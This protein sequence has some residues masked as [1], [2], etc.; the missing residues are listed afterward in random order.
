MR[1]FKKYVNE[2]NE[3]FYLKENNPIIK[4]KNLI[5]ILKKYVTAKD[6]KGK[7][8]VVFNNDIRLKTGELFPAS[9]KHI[10]NCNIHGRQQITYN[11]R[12]S[13]VKIPE[14]Y[15][16][17]CPKCNDFYLSDKYSPTETDRENCIQALQNI[18]FVSSNQ[19]TLKYFKKYMPQ[20]FKIINNFNFEPPL[21]LM[22]SEKIYFLKNKIFYIPECNI[23]NCKE[24][25]ILVKRP[26]FGFG[27]YCEK[28]KNSNY[29]SKKEN[30]IYDFVKNNYINKIEKNYRKFK[31]NELD[32]YLPDLNLGIE[33]NGLYWHSEKHVEKNHHYNKFM[34]FK[35]IGIKLITIWEDDWRFKQNIIKSILCNAMNINQEKIDA[36]KCTIQEIN[37]IEKTKFLNENHIQ[38]NCSSSINIALYHRDTIVSLITFGKNRM[39]LGQKN[40]MNE[41]ELLRFCSKL[42]CNVRGGASKLFNY[43]INNYKPEQIISYANLDIGGGNMYNILGFNNAENTKINY[44][45]SDFQHRYHRSGFM[46]HKLVK[47][48]ADKN[49]T[50]AEIMN[51]RG[52]YRIWGIGNGKWIW[53]RKEN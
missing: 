10:Y 39:I 35:N 19:Q 25:T 45:W 16:I 4:E 14:K 31:N 41:Y 51:E 44:W 11:I 17:Y 40:L 47:E 34:F 7:T 5:W 27:L 8:H 1:G 13:N 32:I 46:K 50:E 22:F 43:F 26:G 6:V 12:L 28:H 38:G 21:N 18:H 42:N 3:I 15:K 53:T 29:S 2:N 33:F 9:S 24:N 36:R 48:G 37:N 23:I 30:E 52:Y 49:K 20:F